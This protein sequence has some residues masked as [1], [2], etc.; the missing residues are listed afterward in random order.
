MSVLAHG[1][2]LV[3]FVVAGWM[4]SP[5]LGVLV[6]GVALVVVGYALDGVSAEAAALAGVRSV[7][8]RLRH[9]KVTP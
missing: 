8:S 9:R 1:A 2:A 4:V 6:L 5:V 7:A 3:A